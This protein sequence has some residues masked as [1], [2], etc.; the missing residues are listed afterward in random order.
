MEDTTIF[1]TKQNIPEQIPKEKLEE[2]PQPPKEKIVITEPTEE[3]PSISKPL[4]IELL[5]I[6]EAKNHFE[7][8][9]LIAQINDF[10]NS[11]TQRMH[12]KDSRKSYEKILNKYL[13]QLKFPDETDIYIKIENLHKIMMIDKKLI[14]AMI[15]K[16][17]L[18]KK[19]IEELTS[20]QLRK[21][22]EDNE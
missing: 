13:K 22:I 4:I 8:P 19:P 20:F 14:E 15:E 3:P 16:E 9:K 21:I 18:K 10:I 5:K 2:K 7:M 12:L 6:G 11:E 1:R 17:E